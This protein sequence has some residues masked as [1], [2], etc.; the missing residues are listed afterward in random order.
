MQAFRNIAVIGIVIAM[1]AYFVLLYQIG[2]LLFRAGL[3]A[4]TSF[5][6]LNPSALRIGLPVVPVVQP[7]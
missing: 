4:G 7:Q 6:S 1:V 2:V 5:A 3:F